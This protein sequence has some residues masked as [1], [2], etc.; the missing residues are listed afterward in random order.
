M[1]YRLLPF[2]L[3][4]GAL[5]AQ[6]P[7][8]DSKRQDILTLMDVSGAVNTLTQIFSRETVEAQMRQ[9]IMK[10]VP[11]GKE[12]E[13]ETFIREFSNDFAAEAPKHIGE[14]KDK[15][16]EIYDKYYSAQDIKDLIAFF[17]TPVGQK[18]VTIAPKVAVE[19]MQI[20]QGW[21]MDLGK[22]IGERVSKRLAERKQ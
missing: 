6:A 19:S 15:V 22:Q 12:Q 13:A 9:M 14:L 17:K 7:A 16:A 21:G 11:A 18:L 8:A 20:G 2:L 3:A 4:A 10:N 1:T 5:L